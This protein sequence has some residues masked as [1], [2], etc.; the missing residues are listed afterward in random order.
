MRH[1]LLTT[2]TVSLLAA[3]N[4]IQPDKIATRL[5]EVVRF[6]VEQ[7][8][9]TGSVLVAKGDQIVLSKAY[10]MANREWNIPNTPTTKFRIG[11][12]TK[13]F[14]AVA[15]LL[16]E[17]QG[18]LKVEDLVKMHWPEAPPAWDKVTIY[19]L[20]TH[21]SGIH[22]VTE[23]PDYKTWQ[24][25][26]T[27][28]E[29]VIGHV[30]DLPLDFPPGSQFKYSNSGYI[31]LGYLVERISGQSYAD[32]LREK[33]FTPLDMKDSGVD[34]NAEI[35]ERRASGYSP[36]EHDAILNAGYLS[37][38]FPHG[39][40][41]L[42]STSEDLLRW[43]RGVFGGK[44]LSPA[45]LQKM[46]TPF[47]DGYAF[48]VGVTTE[49]GHKLISHSGGIQG[50]NANLTYFPDEQITIVVLSNLNGETPDQITRQ[51]TEVIHGED[52]VLPSE[53]KEVQVAEESLKKLE[54]IYEVGP[55]M[56]VII[57]TTG[58]KLFA[59]LGS[60]DPTEM[61]AESP[62]R[63]FVRDSDGQ[64]EFQ[65][66]PQGEV[67]S[68]ALYVE[69]NKA[70]GKRLPERAEIQLPAAVLSRYAGTYALEPDLDVALRRS[71][72]PL[73]FEDFQRPSRVH[74]RQT[75]PRHWPD[76]AQRRK[77]LACTETLEGVDR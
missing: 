53:R 47:K 45:S 72:R 42:Y 62:T 16:L 21:T 59:Q 5:D 18:K 37:M 63:F 14:T 12:V 48:G 50:F 51:L 46:T 55:G 52:V 33:V 58:G 7:K 67:T 73:L 22:S 44:L 77:G 27:T 64:I 74:E 2:L 11:S 6:R 38:T 23:I 26:E 15:I 17:E 1:L 29:Q 36:G 56:N 76:P 66:N 10:G 30:R 32:F 3:C 57:T 9:F 13:Q 39:A 65:Q 68:L 75:G 43:T 19:N 70:D 54:G 24:L 25:S 41:A 34:S 69:G 40:G 8:E 20:L 4:R 28:P 35:I 31:L 60:D 71:R 49:K 61:P